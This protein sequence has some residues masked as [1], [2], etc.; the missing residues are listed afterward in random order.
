[1][2]EAIEKINLLIRDRDLCKQLSRDAYQ[3]AKEHFNRQS[4]IKSYREL[5]LPS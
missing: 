2:S 5:F 3:Y 4:F 1:V